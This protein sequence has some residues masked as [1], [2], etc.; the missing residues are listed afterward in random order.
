MYFFRLILPLSLDLGHIEAP[1]TPRSTLSDKEP[2]PQASFTLVS[3]PQLLLL[4]T[5][6]SE[7]A[8]EILP[9]LST[10]PFHIRW[11]TNTQDALRLALEAE[12][13]LILL[14]DEKA[15]GDITASGLIAE[16]RVRKGP[17]AIWT[18][19]MAGDSK[20]SS[21]D[22]DAFM[23]DC[24]PLP[25]HAAAFPSR[26]LVARQ[27]VELMRQLDHHQHAAR[28]HAEHDS[29]TGLWNRESLLRM[30]HTETDRAQRQ[31]SPLALVLVDIDH[32][33]QVN[34]DYGYDSGDKILQELATRFRRHL[35]SYDMVGR[36]GEDEFLF[37]LPASSSEDA[38]HFTLR[39]RQTVFGKPFLVA[40]D[41]LTISA[42]AGISHSMGRT[43]LV[44]L[45]EAERALANAKVNGRNR[46][47]LFSEIAFEQTLQSASGIRTPS[48]SV[49]R[50]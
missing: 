20:C 3:P 31:S 5:A 39:L 40:R 44:I 48:L 30:L 17:H 42:S 33:S 21:F 29:L 8:N 18:I 24:L 9:A 28:F 15:P 38:A 36:C 1:L 43:P 25:L 37:A 16:I 35:R 10:G 19:L 13:P 23:Q 47:T 7:L 27:A 14:L 2:V 22:A 49:V 12:H 50:H 46:Q 45:R 34:L 11:V 4:V 26:L 41:E 32:F 6:S